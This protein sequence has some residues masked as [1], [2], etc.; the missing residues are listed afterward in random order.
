[1]Q[2]HRITVSRRAR[3]HALGDLDLA[4]EVW[5]VVH[6]YGQLAA[7]FLAPFAPIA[8]NTRAVVAPEALN[9]YYKER[10]GEQ[11][12]TETPV[13]ATWMTR[14]DREAEI[15]DYV[16]YLD[17][18]ADRVGRDD[19]R[20]VALGFSQGVATVTRWVAK[21]TTQVDRLILWAGSLPRDLDLAAHAPRLP[22]R[23]LDVVIGTRDEYASWANVEE[24]RRAIEGAGL[25]LRLHSFEGGHRLDRKTL[26]ALAD[27]EGADSAR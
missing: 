27:D 23:P 18:V 9:R 19:R 7:E 11:T 26:I 14:E 2:E 5:I 1:M 8:S 25:G 20:I 21:G 24:Q 6:G 3:F 4:R 17:A 10:A 12:H 15:A 22:T 13:G 16:D